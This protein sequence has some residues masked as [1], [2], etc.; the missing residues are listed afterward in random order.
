M[1]EVEAINFLNSYSE[2]GNLVEYF[3]LIFILGLKSYSGAY[4]AHYYKIHPT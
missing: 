3:R 1:G 2:S 4:K